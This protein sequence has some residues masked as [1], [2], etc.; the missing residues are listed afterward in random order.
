MKNLKIMSLLSVMLIVSLQASIEQ[1]MNQSSI[2]W[3]KESTPNY[4][5][6]VKEEMKKSHGKV[7]EPSFDVKYAKNKLNS[8]INRIVTTIEPMGHEYKIITETWNDRN[9]S[10]LTWENA[11]LGAAA[12]ATVGGVYAYNQLNNDFDKLGQ[13]LKVA[14]DDLVHYENSRQLERAYI[15]GA[16]LGYKTISLGIDAARV[17][18]Q[19]W[20]S[21]ATIDDL[22]A[23]LGD[24]ASDINE[25]TSIQSSVVKDPNF[26]KE[27]FAEFQAKLSSKDKEQS[28]RFRAEFAAKNKEKLDKFQ[29]ESASIGSNVDYSD[30]KAIKLDPLYKSMSSSTNKDA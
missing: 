9:G 2:E 26:D 10:Y 4:T 5:Y 24:L 7:I 18:S 27:R 6:M 15:K 14:S 21:Q 28:E 22:K 13:D 16:G 23:R 19:F 8:G 11:M 3:V 20:P 29:A 12:L 30:K 1:V 17:Q 25:Y